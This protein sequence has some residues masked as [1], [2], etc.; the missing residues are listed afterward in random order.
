MWA[1]VAVGKVGAAEVRGR[2]EV[3]EAEPGAV[4]A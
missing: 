2:E 1:A 4:G 3:V